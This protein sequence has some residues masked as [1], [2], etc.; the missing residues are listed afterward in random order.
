MRPISLVGT[1]EISNCIALG[2]S[3]LNPTGTRLVRGA[4][5]ARDTA[6]ER[7]DELARG[8]SL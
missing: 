1:V 7:A 8:G 4:T 2:R 3:T 6:L 5:E